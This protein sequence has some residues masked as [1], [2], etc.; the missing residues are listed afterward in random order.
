MANPLVS[1]RN[2]E[3]LLY[4]V[5]RAEELTKL[6]YFAEHGRETFDL[7]L[8]SA[9]KLAR[10]QLFPAFK[11][12]DA[13]P[14]QLVDGQVR[15]HPAMR[16]IWPKLF[17]LGLGNAS[18][19]AEVGGQR[20][21]RTVALMAAYYCMAANGAAMGYLGLTQGAAHLIEAFGDDFLKHEFMT[22]MYAGEWAGTMALTEPHAGS[23]LADVR[24]RAR[25]DGAGWKIDGNKVFIS[26]GD[27]D[28]TAN[29]VHLTLARIED[30]PAGT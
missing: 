10:E 26:G 27:Q 28:V 21:P 16:E 25:K 3:F 22:R 29:I 15:I 23:S 8:T 18:R 5:V 6:P 14:P 17:Q 12:M 7:I 4:E 30:A 24:T 20:L 13:E 1:D 2:V 9:R 11:P 19:P